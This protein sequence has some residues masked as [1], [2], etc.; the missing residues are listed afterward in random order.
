MLYFIQ[1]LILAAVMPIH[2]KAGIKINTG[3]CKLNECRWILIARNPVLI[4]L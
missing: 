3:I 1:F 4:P 2:K